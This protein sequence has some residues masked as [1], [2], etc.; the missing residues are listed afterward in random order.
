MTEA[1]CSLERGAGVSALSAV[2]TMDIAPLRRRFG[3]P[4]NVVEG[5]TGFSSGGIGEDAA[6]AGNSLGSG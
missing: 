5:A 1:A 3:R 6:T 4:P 2:G